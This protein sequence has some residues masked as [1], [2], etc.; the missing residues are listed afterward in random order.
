MDP[1]RPFCSKP[2]E[3]LSIHKDGVARLCCHDWL[4]SPIGTLAPDGQL[5]D[6]W[7]SET[8]QA[9]RRSIL[10]GS[11]T[12][13]NADT[14][15]DLVAGTLPTQAQIFDPF[16]I[17][18]I[19]RQ[20]TELPRG[21]RVI[22]LSY[23]I[24][25]NLKC[26]TCRS[27][28]IMANREEVARLD[29]IQDRVLSDGLDDATE[30]FLSGYGDPLASRV[31]RRLLRTLRHADH[32]RLS[33]QLMT[34]G[35]LLT[36][37]MWESMRDIAPAI[38]LVHVSIDAATRATYLAN[39]GGD[40]ERLLQNLEF[41][42]SLAVRAGRPLLEISF[43]VQANNFREMEAFVEM[44][45]RYGARRILFQRLIHWQSMPDDGYRSAAVHEREHPEFA[46]FLRAL[47]SPV[48]DDG[49]VDFSNLTHLRRLATGGRG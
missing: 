44:G 11:Y 32:P 6:V 49:R 22:S 42:R 2:F 39:R 27:R 24:S 48:F 29:A 40:F 35:L 36:P 17:H 1:A 7:N 23:D 12:F 26:P 41:L 4:P 30:L 38:G 9:I 33:V 25:C 16:L 14:C 31:C 20:R 45:D 37:E 21:P 10:D 47:A 28:L 46:A 8:A 15:P 13:C 43:V 5:R 3:T 18:V 19:S 34:N